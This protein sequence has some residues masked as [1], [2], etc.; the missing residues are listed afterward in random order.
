MEDKHST[1]RGD[2]FDRL[3]HIAPLKK[4]E[5]W[6]TSH[7]EGLL[8]L[9]F[10]GLTTLVSWLS[11]F[12]LANLLSLPA[13]FVANPISWVLAVAFAYL[14]NRTWVFKKHASGLAPI[15]FEILSFCAARVASL[16][17]E[18]A[19]LFLFEKLLGWEGLLLLLVKIA[20][21]VLVVLLNYIFSKLFVFRGKEDAGSE[22]GS[23]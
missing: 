15:L 5:P 4:Y 11:F 23:L 14:T 19:V 2:L 20:T 8:Y 6:L 21:S 17:F 12:I 10:G 9:L 18:T 7:R 13:T 16:F 22:D 1:E 3:F